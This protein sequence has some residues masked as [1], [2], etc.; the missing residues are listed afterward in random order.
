VSHGLKCRIG[1]LAT[2]RAPWLFPQRYV[3]LRLT[4]ELLAREDREL[5]VAVGA[6]FADQA[7]SAAIIANQTV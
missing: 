7:I 1:D 3:E 2:A 5:I 4:D 6:Y